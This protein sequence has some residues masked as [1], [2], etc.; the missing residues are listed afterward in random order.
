M[1]F[2]VHRDSSCDYHRCVNPVQYLK[3]PKTQEISKASVYFFNRIPNHDLSMLKKKG[4]KIVCDIDDF[5]ELNEEHYLYHH[6]K[7]KG[8][9]ERIINSLKLADVV[10][11]THGKLADKVK[12]HNKNVYVVPNAIPYE[13]GQFNIG[14]QEWTGKIGFVGGMSH[15][16][17]V[18]L[19]KG[20][21]VPSQVHISQY[22]EHYK[23]L[24]I[25]VAPLIKNE[26]N[27]HK[28]N[29]K[30]LEAACGHAM[31]VCSNIHPF[32]NPLDR[33]YVDLCA[34]NDWTER[35]NYLQSN[36]NYARDKAELLAEHCREHYNL[37]KVNN[38]RKEIFLELLRKG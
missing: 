23:G 32:D 36:P 5:W 31:A 12:D 18:E 16:K 15:Y 6:F 37:L 27:E 3:L 35:L 30:V 20:V 9:A 21:S 25:C 10:I 33:P 17:D 7:V 26:F 1:L 29:L 14:R 4:I 34:P 8:M 19:V 24:N 2:T 11:T 13:Q 28:S 22:M 38:L